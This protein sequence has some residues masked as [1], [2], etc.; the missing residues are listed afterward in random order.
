[1]CE[2]RCPRPLHL[3]DFLD[4]P[5]GQETGGSPSLSSFDVAGVSEPD[6]SW[7]DKALSL[8]KSIAGYGEFEA[9]WA[10]DGDATGIP[11]RA[12]ARYRCGGQPRH[13]P[14]WQQRRNHGNRGRGGGQFRI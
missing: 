7:W 10:A 6:R 5:Q 9:E 4:V 1:M 14:V 2:E 12:K 11:A 13:W 8:A 3:E